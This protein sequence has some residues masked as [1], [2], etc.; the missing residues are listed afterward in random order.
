MVR[1]SCSLV[2]QKTSIIRP[3][4]TKSGAALVGTER[5]GYDRGFAHWRSRHGIENIGDI[6]LSF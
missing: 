4:R 1:I 3:Y 6:P 2:W 5:P